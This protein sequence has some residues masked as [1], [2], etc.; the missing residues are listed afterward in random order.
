[1]AIWR[2]VD[3]HSETWV[4]SRVRLASPTRPRT[5]SQD[6]DWPLGRSESASLGL[7]TGVPRLDARGRE[8]KPR[9]GHQT[10]PAIP[11]DSG[12]F[13][14]SQ[15]PDSLSFLDLPGGDLVHL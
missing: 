4:C 6:G 13:L 1:M 15:G 9:T 10:S 12:E 2:V 5:R 8:A 7:S 11:L 3:G 14:S